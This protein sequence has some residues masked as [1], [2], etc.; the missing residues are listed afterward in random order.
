MSRDKWDQRIQ[1]AAELAG[2]FPFAAEGLRFYEHVASFQKSLYAGLAAG[3]G[4]A[5]KSR[6]PGGLRD[7]LELFVLLPWFGSF[8][9]FVQDIAPAPLAQSAAALRAAGGT[10]WEEVLDEAWRT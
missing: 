3:N 9:S 6:P 8:L 4:A 7:E 1:R 5:K 10:R 2:R